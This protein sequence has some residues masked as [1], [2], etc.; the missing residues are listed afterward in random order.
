MV[1]SD[2]ALMWE[3]LKIVHDKPRHSQSQESIG[4]ANRDMEEMLFSWLEENGDEMDEW[5]TL[6]AGKENN[7]YHAGLKC[8]PYNAYHAGLKCS[9]YETMMLGQ[10]MKIGLKT[11]YIPVE[12]VRTL[13]A[14]DL[15]AVIE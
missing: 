1:I 15:A 8:S 12:V 7:T 4:R 2:L 9:P 6:C 3:D 13:D 10:P 14:E 5:F 11:S